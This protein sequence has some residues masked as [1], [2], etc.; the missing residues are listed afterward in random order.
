MT[1]LSYPVDWVEAAFGRI[2]FQ[3]F[4]IRL[5]YGDS[6]MGRRHPFV[7]GRRG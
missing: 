3:D 5:P 1:M 2:G 6:A 7:F 4:E